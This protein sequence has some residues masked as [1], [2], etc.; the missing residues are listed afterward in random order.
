MRVLSREG[1]PLIEL[2]GEPE[3]RDLSG[4]PLEG[5]DPGDYDLSGS[6]LS[7]ADEMRETMA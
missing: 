1:G 3:G 4:V 2:A 7:G 6:N 5:A